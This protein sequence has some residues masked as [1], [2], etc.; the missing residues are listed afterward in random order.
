MFDF[1]KEIELP[2]KI[3]TPDKTIRVAVT[4]F[5]GSGKTVFLTSLINQLI[6]AD[7]L[8]YLHE[9]IGRSFV[10]RLL[11]PDNLFV[12]FDYYGKLHAFRSDDPHWPKATRTVTKTTLQLEFKSAYRFLENQIV[13]LE[14]IDYPGEW[15]MDLSML[16]LSYRAWSRQMLDLSAAPMR[17][18]YAR[19]WRSYLERIDLYG[20]SL[21]EAD[22]IVHDLYREYLKALHY[23]AF[24]FVQPGR[25]LEPGDMN[26][27][28]M[29]L[30]APLPAPPDGMY[31]PDSL[32]ARFAKR[33]DTYLK[34]VVR[35]LY[36]EHFQSF[37]TQIVLVDL[38]KTL[39][40]GYD[41]FLDMHQAFRHILKSFS[42]GTNPFLARLFRTKIDHVIFA[43]TKADYIP[44]SQYNSYQH[45]LKEM[46]RDIKNEL[47]LSHIDSEVTIFS[48]VKSTDYVKAKVDGKVLEC[49]RGIVEGE[50]E[51]SVHFPGLLPQHYKRNSFWKEAKFDFP[52]F[53]PRPFPPTDKEA[54]EHIRMDRLI[55][56]MLR[57]SV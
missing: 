13:N 42:Y 7:K 43:A 24:S 3:P 53:K 2:F 4:G 44:P 56:A 9:K 30:F 8:P 51:P 50:R 46:I 33:Y 21:E 6:A 36:L 18:R 11:P 12:R 48:S 57:R 37:D 38:I 23:N 10:A 20:A 45:L 25:F 34:E 5:S 29:L 31:H 1:L 40:H 15:L 47:L 39:Q 22:E 52:R 41:A 17:A 49:I 55:Y 54:V 32:Y 14:L 26:N 35:R 28:P 27:D 16:D 19:E